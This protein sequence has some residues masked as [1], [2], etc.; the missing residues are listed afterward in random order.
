MAVRS[1]QIQ[2]REVLEAAI[3][4]AIEWINSQDA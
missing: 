1:A 3:R 2:R 4:V